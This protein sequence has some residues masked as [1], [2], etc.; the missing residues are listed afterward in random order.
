M[1][2]GSFNANSSAG[3]AIS[4]N[5]M[6]A[7]AAQPSMFFYDVEKGNQA[8]FFDEN[9]LVMAG[10]NKSEIATQLNTPI[11]LGNNRADAAS[12]FY[13]T[14]YSASSPCVI[15]AL[16]GVNIGGPASMDGSTAFGR[17]YQVGVSK[18]TII[19]SPSAPCLSLD[20]PGMWRFRW[21]VKP[22]VR[23]IY[24]NT[25]QVTTV[26]TSSL[27]PSIVVKANPDIGLNADISA[28]AA[29]SQDWV[30]I[31]PL[32]FV[33]TGTGVTWVELHNNNTNELNTPAFFDH[34][35]GT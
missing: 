14:E 2:S 22:G 13:G 33:A 4:L 16:Q 26:F 25:K 15:G 21:V 19:G 10:T 34:I 5:Q 27:R 32:S 35:V 23:A 3:N 30:T 20:I 31:G 12:V 1:A 9:V 29:T 6:Q 28:S 18:S 24:V 7:D 8:G 17:N 11:M